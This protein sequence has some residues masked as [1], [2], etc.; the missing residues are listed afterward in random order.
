MSISDLKNIFIVALLGSAVVGCSSEP[1][2]E[3]EAEAKSTKVEE[4]A[5]S[6][7]EEA[8]K[9]VVVIPTNSEGMTAEQLLAAIQGKVVN[10][11]FDR[12]EVQS[13]FYAL[14]KMSADYMALTDS[15][16]V[17]LKGYADERGTPEYNLALGERRGI[18]VKD[19]L[20]A[21]GIS[22]S[23]INVI[24]YGEE[25][26]VAVGHDDASWSQ[27]RRVEFSY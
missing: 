16:T 3:S 14:L 20:V 19:A 25:N 13:D 18:A 15:A 22:P 5:K 24:S 9:D 17:T 8:K 1:V 21:Q 6:T 11:E 10:F 27:N 23:R 26:P 12:S 7:S 4:V 2:A